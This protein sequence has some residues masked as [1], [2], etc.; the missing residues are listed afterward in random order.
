MFCTKCGSAAS[1]L[2]SKFCIACGSTI[3][4]AVVNAPPA[5]SNICWNCGQGKQPIYGGCA[6]CGSNLAGEQPL[7]SAPKP[8]RNWKFVV[9]TAAGVIIALIAW[10]FS[11]GVARETEVPIQS[12]GSAQSLATSVIELAPTQIERL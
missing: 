7:A 8:E 11:Q 4:A 2:G 10:G 5:D 3:S 9:I 1:P 12:S 6:K